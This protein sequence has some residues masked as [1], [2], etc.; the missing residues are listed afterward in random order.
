V[1]KRRLLLTD[2]AG[3]YLVPNLG[4]GDYEVSVAADGFETQTAKVTLAVG[5]Q[6]NNHMRL[7]SG[8]TPPDLKDLGFTPA[9]SQGSAQ[10]SGIAGMS[11][12]TC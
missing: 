2:P 7:R 8:G 4:P 6:Q 12:P 11:A 10:E 5:A 9:Q 1:G 3:V